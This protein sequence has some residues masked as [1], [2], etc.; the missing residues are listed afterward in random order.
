[1]DAADESAAV[2]CA[3]GDAGALKRHAVARRAR[4][5]T[6]V[7]GGKNVVAVAVRLGSIVTERRIRVRVPRGM[8]AVDYLVG[9]QV[10]GGRRL[11][12]TDILVHVL[13]GAAVM[14]RRC[15]RV[16]AIAVVIMVVAVAIAGRRSSVMVQRRRRMTAVGAVHV[17]AGVAMMIGRRGRVAAAAVVLVL[18]G[19]TVLVSHRYIAAVVR[20]I[21]DGVVVAT[22]FCERVGRDRFDRWSQWHSDHGRQDDEMRSDSAELAAGP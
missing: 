6:S 16:T 20:L 17:L 12:T 13:E 15:R 18:A 10:I 9:V 1:M 3:R 5:H 22:F 21:G 7:V 4:G 2:I 8:P 14:V 11:M 19:R